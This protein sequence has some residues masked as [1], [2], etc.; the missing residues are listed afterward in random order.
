MFIKLSFRDHIR[1]FIFFIP[2]KYIA[3]SALVLRSL[4]SLIKKKPK[5][6]W[7]NSNAIQIK[8][9]LTLTLYFLNVLSLSHQRK[10][11]EAM[12]S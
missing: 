3:K 5:G 6:F 8:A 7:S 12:N 4:E 9:T 2:R 1:T 10:L 11:I